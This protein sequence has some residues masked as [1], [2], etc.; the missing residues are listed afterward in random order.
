MLMWKSILSLSF[1]SKYATLESLVSYV[2]LFQFQVCTLSPMNYYLP[3]D[4]V[5]AIYILEPEKYRAK[6]GTRVKTSRAGVV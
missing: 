5:Q 4:Q 1:E 2:C 6:K 3:L